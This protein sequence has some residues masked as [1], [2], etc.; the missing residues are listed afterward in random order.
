MNNNILLIDLHPLVHVGLSSAF[1]KKGKQL[2]WNNGRSE[3]IFKFISTLQP[4]MI[5]IDIYQSHYIFRKMF[6]MLES[7][8]INCKVIVFSEENNLLFQKECYDIGV[9]AYI[10]KSAEVSELLKAIDVLD[11]EDRYFPSLNTKLM[12]RKINN[13]DN[14]INR[15]LSAREQ[16]VLKNLSA[17]YSV[18]E[19]SS[20]LELNIKTVSTHKINLIKKLGCQN[21]VH[22]LNVARFHEV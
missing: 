14:Y 4:Y 1:T 12:P 19:I 13:F 22:A 3:D 17:G 21:L 8:A 10:S 16:D 9:N 15:R 18:K 7:L 6:H 11:Y 20:L 5:I 2:I